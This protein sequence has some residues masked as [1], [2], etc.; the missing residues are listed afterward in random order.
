[1]TRYVFGNDLFTG[2]NISLQSDCLCFNL[3]FLLEETGT[4]TLPRKDTLFIYF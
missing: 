1:M 3:F 2:D 4:D